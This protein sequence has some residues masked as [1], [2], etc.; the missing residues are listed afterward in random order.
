MPS[1]KTKNQTER[2]GALDFTKGILVLFM[3]LYH[4]LNYHGIFPNRYLPFVAPGFI[5]ISGFIISS[6]YFLKYGQDINRGRKRLAVRSIKLL[7]IFTILN[8]ASRIAWPAYNDGILGEIRNFAGNWVEIYLVGSPRKVAFDVLIPIGYTLMA[9]I[10][11]P[12]SLPMGAIIIVLSAISAFSANIFL[13]NNT[14]SVYMLTMTSAGM[15]GMAMGLLPAQII[16]AFSR[17]WMRIGWLF[18]CYGIVALCGGY[19]Y[20]TQIL[21]TLIALI[22][23]YSIGGRIEHDNRINKKIILYGQY[24]LLSYI[25]QI[26][27]LKMMFL[28]VLKFHLLNPK[29]ILTISLITILTYLVIAVVDFTRFKC[30][31]IDILYRA[32]FA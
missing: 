27:L 16:N 26:A 32:V 2:I 21:S 19:Y 10:F 4:S 17:S 31:K 5:M 15:I 6:I 14:G 30:R 1:L 29:I 25:V 18:V 8:I 20:A 23:I 7:L 22:I 11:V 3:I 9:A 12:R 24:S 13:E 28:L